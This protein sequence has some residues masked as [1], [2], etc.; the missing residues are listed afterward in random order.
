[1]Q[2]LQHFRHTL[3]TFHVPVILNNNFTELNSFAVFHALL[4]LCFVE[5][6]SLFASILFYN[7]YIGYGFTHIVN[8]RSG[9]NK[10]CGSVNGD[11]QQ[12]LLDQN[13]FYGSM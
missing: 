7:L 8:G 1:M 2:V 6:S 3:F 5:H 4:K 13:Y 11:T 9:S 12:L 10:K